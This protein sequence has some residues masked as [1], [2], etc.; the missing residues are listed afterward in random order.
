MIVPDKS[1][2]L[3]GTGQKIPFCNVQTVGSGGTNQNHVVQKALRSDTNCGVYSDNCLPIPAR[4]GDDQSFSEHDMRYSQTLSESSATLE[5][6]MPSQNTLPATT[7]NTVMLNP[8][9]ITC[10]PLQS[11]QNVMT[12]MSSP[13]SQP[14]VQLQQ[15]QIENYSLKNEAASLE[16]L[17]YD[18]KDMVCDFEGAMATDAIGV[19]QFNHC[20]T[21]TGSG[22]SNGNTSGGSQAESGNGGQSHYV[23]GYSLQN[24]GSSMVTGGNG[25]GGLGGGGDDDPSK[26]NRHLQRSHYTEGNVFEDVEQDDFARNVSEPCINARLEELGCL[27]LPFL[28]HL[29]PSE[30][31]NEFDNLPRVEP[32]E[33]SSDLASPLPV[34]VPVTPVP[35][36]AIAIPVSESISSSPPVHNRP[37]ELVMQCT[38]SAGSH[39]SDTSTPQLSYPIQVSTPQQQQQT[40]PPRPSQQLQGGSIPPISPA[41]VPTPAN[42]CPFDCSRFEENCK[43]FFE[44]V[45][46]KDLPTEDFQST[47]DALLFSEKF[48]MDI[49]EIMRNPC[50]LKVSNHVCATVADFRFDSEQ[51]KFVF[52]I[53]AD[54]KTLHVHM[55]IE[56]ERCVCVCVWGGGG[57]GGL[58][59][60]LIASFTIYPTVPLFK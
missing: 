11:A 23:T 45:V 49:G 26:N 7:T 15:H 22:S 8:M 40:L 19:P 18:D 52:S 39:M 47:R 60:R 30:I 25:G 14:Q 48:C 24:C 5:V 13:N 35:A 1:L 57:G 41:V 51:S 55:F 2:V 16:D 4:S 27:Q 59:E 50:D 54:C 42:D 32:M 46:R 21:G 43:I 34:S 38:S 37:S 44:L 17:M 31:S 33:E 56:R 29:E 58:G 53:P 9:E 28:H 6:N 20:P 36:T 10:S 12:A 3:S